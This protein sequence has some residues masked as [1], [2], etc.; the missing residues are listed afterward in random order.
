MVGFFKNVFCYNLF[1]TS[2]INTM[3]KWAIL[4]FTRTIN[5]KRFFILLSRYFC[6]NLSSKLV[7]F[8]ERSLLM[9]YQTD[10][11]SLFHYDFSKKKS[12]KTNFVYLRA[13][14]DK[15]GLLQKFYT[16]KLRMTRI[17][18]AFTKSNVHFFRRFNICSKPLYQF[19]QQ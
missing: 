18:I 6:I 11:V 14:I 15:L 1:N 3:N 16:P 17:S 4:E 8:K 9:L 13:F 2:V 5:L 10:L 12:V 19:R 7:L